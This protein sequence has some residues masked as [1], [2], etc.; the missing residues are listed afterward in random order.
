MIALYSVGAESMARQS[1]T[2][3]RI[4]KV[5]SLSNNNDGAEEDEAAVNMDDSKRKDFTMGCCHFVV[6]VPP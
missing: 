3:N 5:S 1:F 4:A 2:V 6:T